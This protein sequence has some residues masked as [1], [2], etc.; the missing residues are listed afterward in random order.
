MDTLLIILGILSLVVGM[1]GCIVPML[2]GPPLGYLGILLLHF[3]DKVQLSTGELVWGAV[4]V[5]IVQVLDYITPMLGTKYTG[6][7]R[8][9]NWGSFIGTIVG[10]FFL[11]L[12]LILGPFIGAL[13]GALRDGN[14]Q[15]DALKAGL[16]AVIGFLA[17]T[18]LKF[19]ACGYFIYLFIKHLL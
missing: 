7:G 14:N 4:I 18:I 16:G 17:G 12:G 13:L 5:V 15:S 19:V 6:A 10:L 3:T 1:L 2:P 9:A 11:P 8:W